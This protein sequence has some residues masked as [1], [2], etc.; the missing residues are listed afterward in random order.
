MR[1]SCTARVVVG[2]RWQY[3]V[4]SK[5]IRHWNAEGRLLLVDWPELYESYLA[6]E[7]K[8]KNQKRTEEIVKRYR[9]LEERTLTTETG[10]LWTSY[11]DWEIFPATHADVALACNYEG[12]GFE[13]GLDSIKGRLSAHE[14]VRRLNN[15][16]QGIREAISSRIGKK[17]WETGQRI[18]KLRMPG[19]RKG[20]GAWVIGV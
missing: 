11:G 9:K 7:R 1:P 6:Q 8:R 14:V 12:R 2:S 16:A 5:V 19:S 15:L 20:A 18:S 4:P 3:K 17:K 13:D 10:G